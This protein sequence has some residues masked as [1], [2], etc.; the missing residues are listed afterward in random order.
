MILLDII[1]Y[2]LKFKEELL[3]ERRGTH[4]MRRKNRRKNRAQR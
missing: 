4:I 3:V 2:K 1:N